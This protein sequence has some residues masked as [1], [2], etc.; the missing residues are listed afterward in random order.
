MPVSIVFYKKQHY[1]Q[2]RPKNS[3][4]TISKKL[5]KYLNFTHNIN[6][7]GNNVQNTNHSCSMK[8]IVHFLLMLLKKLNIYSIIIV[9]LMLVFFCLLEI[10]ICFVLLNNLLC[11][12][13]CFSEGSE[14]L[15]KLRNQGCFALKNN[16]MKDKF[17]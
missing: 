7:N 16:K 2:I 12:Y 13:S 15:P 8:I 17:H 3:H 10:K 5:V 9:L 14:T 4:M 1:H 6:I 11:N